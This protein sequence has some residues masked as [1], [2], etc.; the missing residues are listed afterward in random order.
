MRLVPFKVKGL[1]GERITSTYRTPEHNRAVGGVENS[2]HTRRD[3]WGNPLARDSVPPK[4]M[5]M[6]EYADY[7][8]KSNPQYEVIPEDDHVHVEPRG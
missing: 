5:S 3:R 1:G 4:G 7:L 2:Y 6:R 8:R